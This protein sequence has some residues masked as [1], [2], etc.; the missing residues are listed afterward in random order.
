LRNRAG[1]LDLF[2][3]EKRWS[4]KLTSNETKLTV[5]REKPVF[6]TCRSVFLNPPP[7]EAGNHLSW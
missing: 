6:A 5:W 3:A 7:A 2:P 1:F 4:K